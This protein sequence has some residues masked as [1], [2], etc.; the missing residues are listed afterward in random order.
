MT[1]IPFSCVSLAERPHPPI[2]LQPCL[3][4]TKMVCTDSERVL[5]WP[6]LLR[7]SHRPVKPFPLDVISSQ[8]VVQKL[9]FTLSSLRRAI[10]NRF[11]LPYLPF[12][13]RPHPSRSLNE[14]NS[15]S[16]VG[17]IRVVSVGAAEEEMTGLW[18]SIIQ[19]S[20]GVFFSYFFANSNLLLSSVTVTK[21][22]YTPE[23]SS[24]ISTIAR[25]CEGC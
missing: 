15:A 10:L 21:R 7:E 4:S 8:L 23:S 2:S 1:A 11:S 6:M 14:S 22:E 17:E 12:P 25:L 5:L 16:G 9:S 24:F 19:E 13:S 3:W 20:D 18:V